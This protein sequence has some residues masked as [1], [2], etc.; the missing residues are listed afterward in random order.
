[1]QLAGRARAV[2]LEAG[3]LEAAPCSLLAPSWGN[4]HQEIVC[5]LLRAAK[6]K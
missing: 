2:L 5:W 1:M 4:V 3:S 6:Q